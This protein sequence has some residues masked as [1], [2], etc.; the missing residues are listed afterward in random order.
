[1]KKR[2]VYI[3][4]V[5]PLLFSCSGNAITASE[6]NDVLLGIVEAQESEEVLASYKDVKLVDKIQIQGVTTY[7][8]TYV[9]SEANH[10]YSS[11]VNGA[12]SA[13]Y[14]LGGTETLVMTEGDEIKTSVDDSDISSF[15]E[16][17]SYAISMQMEQTLF[18][19][20]WCVSASSQYMSM[21]QGYEFAFESSGAGDLTVKV[22]LSVNHME[23]VFRNNLPVS[24]SI[25]ELLDVGYENRLM[26]FAYGTS[27]SDYSR[28]I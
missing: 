19:A 21:S 16:S 4:L 10:Y 22:S 12:F 28:P 17:V 8:A 26:T 13:V 1:M 24:Y 27:E 20:Y 9:Y 23:T 6:A 14:E 18:L 11:L 25:S 7:E 5:M 15:K 3:S 2:L